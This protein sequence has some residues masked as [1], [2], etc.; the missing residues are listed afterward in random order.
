MQIKLNTYV[1]LKQNLRLL[2][3][4]FLKIKL[5]P[6]TPSSGDEVPV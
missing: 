6:T 5:L 4:N 1:S 2:F 3:A